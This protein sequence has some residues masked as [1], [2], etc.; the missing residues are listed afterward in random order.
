MKKFRKLLPALSMLLIS[1]LLMGSSTFAWFSMNTTV[2]ATGMQVT[3]TAASS[4][5]ITNQSANINSTATNTQGMTAITTKIKPATHLI[6]Q[7]DDSNSTLTYTDGDSY[8]VYVTNE[9][10]VDAVTGNAQTGKTLKYAKATNSAS[11][12]YYI[13]YTV[14]IAAKGQPLNNQKLTAKI[15]DPDLNKSIYNAISIDFWVNG[16]FK[17]TD[18]FKAASTTG[19]Y[20]GNDIFEGVIPSAGA[21]SSNYITVLMRV[22][23]DGAMESATPGTTYVNNGTI[24]TSAVTFGVEFTA[25]EKTGI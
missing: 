17:C 14:Y 13:D 12:N 6:D 8:L 24:D 19:S 7:K 4:L 10:D 18:S 5:V 2:S 22:Y 20:S 1:A 11:A 25:A 16:S 23:F 3:A 21:T 9:A 15:I